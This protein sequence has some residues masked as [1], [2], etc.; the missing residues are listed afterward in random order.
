MRT[1]CWQPVIHGR[2]DTTNKA[3]EKMTAKNSGMIPTKMALRFSELQ[4]AHFYFELWIIFAHFTF[5]T[6]CTLISA[7][8]VESWKARL[9]LSSITLLRILNLLISY[10]QVVEKNVS[11]W[12]V[13]AVLRFLNWYKML[14]LTVLKQKSDWRTRWHKYRRSFT[15]A[16]E[17]ISRKRSGP[18]LLR[19]EVW[20]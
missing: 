18:S 10:G 16:R 20:P 5:I 9:N 17:I 13:D 19:A 7:V 6:C 15:R 8:V 3:L 12:I 1:V 4:N 2:S 14:L 11:V